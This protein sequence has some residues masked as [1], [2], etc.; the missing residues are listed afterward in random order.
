MKILWETRCSNYGVVPF[1]PPLEGL[2][3]KQL[4]ESFHLLDPQ[5]PCNA[6]A[7]ATLNSRPLTARDQTWEVY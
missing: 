4:I 1:T 5:V 3:V 7:E 6:Q 2:Y